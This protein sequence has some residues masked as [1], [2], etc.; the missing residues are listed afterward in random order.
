[1]SMLSATDKPT[2]DVQDQDEPRWSP[3]QN[4]AES[5]R[6]KNAKLLPAK[7]YAN[8]QGSL[9]YRADY[10]LRWL[11]VAKR[12]RNAWCREFSTADQARDV[13]TMALASRH[14]LDW[15]ERERA[16]LRISKPASAVVKDSKRTAM[17]VVDVVEAATPVES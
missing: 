17:P 1:M 5:R 10:E 12:Q 2:P 9:Y 7:I 13:A 16:I 15:C 6:P 14:L 11:R 3:P 8:S 4:D